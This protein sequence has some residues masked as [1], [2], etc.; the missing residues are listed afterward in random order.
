MNNFKR[1]GVGAVRK[2]RE[3]T[4]GNR[5]NREQIEKEKLINIFEEADKKFNKPCGNLYALW[6]IEQI[7]SRFL[8]SKGR[9]GNSY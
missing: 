7:C 3:G 9:I 6:V 4:P 2:R 1:H 5:V 8:W